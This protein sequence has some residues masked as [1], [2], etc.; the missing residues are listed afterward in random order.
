MPRKTKK[1]MNPQALRVWKDCVKKAKAKRAGSKAFGFISG[2]TLLQARKY[3]CVR[4]Y[5]S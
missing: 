2:P 1:K 5:G 3:Y 4:G